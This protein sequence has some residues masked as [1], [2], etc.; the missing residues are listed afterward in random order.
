MDEA[1]KLK[2]SLL[3]TNN[4]ADLE[5]I[6][7]SDDKKEKNRQWIRARH[8]DIYLNQTVEIMDKIIANKGKNTV[9]N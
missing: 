3:I 6:N 2:D 1:Y 8:S 5:N 7:L 4:T 9:N